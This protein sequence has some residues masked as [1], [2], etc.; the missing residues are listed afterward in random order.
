MQLVETIYCRASAPSGVPFCFC[1]SL[2]WPPLLVRSAR[3]PERF[4]PV[5]TAIHLV[6]LPSFVL[7]PF[8]VF[9]GGGFGLGSTSML[10]LLPVSNVT[11]FSLRVNVLR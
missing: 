6:V 4:D 7:G 2:I 11:K 8:I 3:S 9:K 5:D 1:I 10:T